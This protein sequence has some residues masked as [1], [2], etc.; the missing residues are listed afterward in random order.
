MERIARRSEGQIRRKVGLPEFLQ[1]PRVKWLLSSHVCFVMRHRAKE[2]R[3]RYEE[4]MAQYQPPDKQANR[5]R[6]KT[7]YNMFFSS[8][9][10][11]LKQTESGVPSERGSVARLVGT[12]WKQLSNDEKMYYER[13]ADKHNGM[14]P[15]KDADEEE[16]EEEMKAQQHMDHHYAY[17]PVHA[18][19]HMQHVPPPPPPMHGMPQHPGAHDPR[20]HH[21]YPPPP[22]H[23]MYGPNAYGHYDYSQHHQRHPPQGRQSAYQY[24]Y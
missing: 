1:A 11:R 8:H 21:Y 7:G 3:K 16:D 17:P 19:M 10:L 12:A 18:E 24:H 9:V 15:V 2:D 22:P 14:N 4:Q 23:H 13:E 20:A 5:K 6:N